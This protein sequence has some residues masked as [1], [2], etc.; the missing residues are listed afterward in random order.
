MRRKKQ[1]QSDLDRYLQ[2]HKPLC[3]MHIYSDDNRRCTCGLNGA[4][5]E[6]TEMRQMLARLMAE[7]R[8]MEMEV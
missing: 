7:P 5:R 6:L 4:L 8:Q 2:G 1:R 3:R